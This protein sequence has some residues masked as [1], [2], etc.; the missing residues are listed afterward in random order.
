MTARGRGLGVLPVGEADCRGQPPGHEPDSKADE[1][2]GQVVDD[3]RALTGSV[4]QRDEPLRRLDLERQHDRGGDDR[5]LASG[6][7][8]K[9]DRHPKR[10]EQEDVEA[11][12]AELE[13]LVD[14]G[15]TDP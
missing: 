6:P 1:Q 11:P 13:Y 7:R 2:P 15:Q 14:G 5:R 4:E 9:A 3:V 10:D 12:V 8:E